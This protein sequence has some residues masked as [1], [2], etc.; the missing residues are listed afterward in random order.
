MGQGRPFRAASDLLQHMGLSATQVAGAV[1]RQ[2]VGQAYLLASTDLFRLSA[3]LCIVLSAIVWVTR[4]PSPS[5]AAH[6]AA[7]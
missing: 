2:M 3:I 6:A 4:R 7:D 1:T 5:G